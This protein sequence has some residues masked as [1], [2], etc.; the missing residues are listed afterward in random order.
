MSSSLEN[1]S[2]LFALQ[3]YE[4]A[5]TRFFNESGVLFLAYKLVSPKS[6]PF[7]VFLKLHLWIFNFLGFRFRRQEFN[8]SSYFATHLDARFNSRFSEIKN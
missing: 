3:S 2:A 1:F 4:V 5:V 7:S 6:T 8:G